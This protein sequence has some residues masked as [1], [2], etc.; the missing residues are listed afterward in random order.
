MYNS[1]LRYGL[2][3][4]VER[5]FKDSDTMRGIPTVATP[6]PLVDSTHTVS[7]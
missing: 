6:P 5:D 1:R 4:E 7:A 2:Q 3:F